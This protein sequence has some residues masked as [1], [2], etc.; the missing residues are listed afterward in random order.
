M[1]QSEEYIIMYFKFLFVM[2][3]RFLL[4]E[5]RSEFVLFRLILYCEML[6]ALGIRI[7][8]HMDTSMWLH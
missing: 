6:T 2:E 3:I 5:A 7:S 8:L 1:F 4:F